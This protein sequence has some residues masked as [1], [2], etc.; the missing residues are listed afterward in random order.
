MADAGFMTPEVASQLVAQGYLSPE[1]AQGFQG[2]LDTDRLA[3]QAPVIQDQPTV[4]A[5]AAVPAPT[6]PPGP[7]VPAQ[8][9]PPQPVPQGV[10]QGPP[11]PVVNVPPTTI[12]SHESPQSLWER[13]NQSKQDTNLAMAD[14][15]KQRAAETALKNQ[16]T[17]QQLR[18]NAAERQRVASEA[19][20]E[21]QQR[22]A[23]STERAKAIANMQVDPERYVHDKSVLGKI[24][25]VL[26]LAL[27]GFAGGYN[28]TENQ[29]MKMLN[30]AIDRDVAAQEKRI[31]N[32][33]DSARELDRLS[34]ER[35]GHAMDKVQFLGQVRQDLLNT[36]QLELADITTKYEGPEAQQKANELNAGIQ[37]ELA[38]HKQQYVDRAASAAAAA[39]NKA[40]ESRKA[41]GE[42]AAKLMEPK[43][44]QPGM[45]AAEAADTA[46]RLLTGKGADTTGLSTEARP[47]KLT[48]EEKAAK[49]AELEATE[50]VKT[51]KDF[52]M[53]KVTEGGSLGNLANETLPGGLVPDSVKENAQVR[54]DYNTRA[55]M[56][57]AGSY[58]LDT[59]A[60][61]PKNM[62]RVEEDA[63]PY[64]IMPGDDVKVAEKK[65]EALVNLAQRTAA[66][67]GA[68]SQTKADR[69]KALGFTPKGQ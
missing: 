59:N 57:V 4:P 5:P 50:N 58:K 61:E 42:L 8:P 36:A 47:G 20:K 53:K 18:D 23:E 1:V 41:V 38:T 6:P 10:P 30:A 29:N 28:H 65:R 52:D 48:D 12:A 17:A 56:I 39:A 68:P 34:K 54:N 33:K 11:S 3:G 62:K 66:A 45:S 25:M 27:G 14:L 32:A 21:W 40:A 67:Q 37:Q 44:G 49:K 24:G 31:D 46:S 69:D 19:D 15:V 51:L 43:E 55:R 7:P 2:Q 60:N 16:E 22:Q 26:S 13:A 64:V 63:K 9:V 35:Y